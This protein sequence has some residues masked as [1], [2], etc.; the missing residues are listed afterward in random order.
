MGNIRRRE[1]RKG[2]VQIP[3]QLTSQCLD[4]DDDLRGKK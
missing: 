1:A 4:L 3:G 2:N